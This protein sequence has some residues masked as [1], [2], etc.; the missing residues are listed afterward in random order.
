MIGSIALAC[1]FR[2]RHHDPV[3]DAQR[4]RPAALGTELDAR[5]QDPA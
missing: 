2:T 4:T 1:V 3:C 5:P